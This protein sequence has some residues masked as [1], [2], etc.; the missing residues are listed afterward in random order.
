VEIHWTDRSLAGFEHQPIAET[1]KA[2]DLV[3]F[4]HPFSGDIVASNCFLPLDRALPDWLGE[5]ADGLYVGP[6]LASYRFGGAVWGAPIDA[7][8][9]HAIY[10]ANVLAR[11]G[12]TPPAT[13]TEVIGLGG[14]LRKKGV[15]L[16]AAVVTP[17]L[18]LVAAA[19]MANAGKPWP[20]PSS[21]P[22][23]VDRD[24]L[25]QAL[26]SLAEL[27]S[28]CPAE[29]LGWDSIALHEAMVS[30]RDIAYA[31]CVYGYAT[32][33][34]ADMPA[35][36]SFGDFPGAVAPYAA[37]TAIGGTALGVSSNT[38]HPE[39]CFDFVRFALS[40]RAQIDL[41]AGNHGQPARIEAWNDGATDAAFHGY[42]SGVRASMERAW[43]RPRR[44]GYI[45]FQHEFGHL[46]ARFARR[47]IGLRA[48]LDA[49]GALAAKLD[50]TDAAT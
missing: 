49:V 48:A 26:E 12:E 38:A 29:A 3:I 50:R 21:E 1:A 15:F 33:G 40:A 19:L 17:H 28:Y 13:W 46:A 4:D 20:T 23:A 5:A 43:I 25:Q 18:G 16:G 6:T 14:R 41:I 42:Y 39:A 22:F 36:L 35:R 10:R 30:R 9:E 7:A 37:G 24:A 27:V 44:A 31:P 2:F 45:P 11:A 8:T 34:E 32:Y 47:E